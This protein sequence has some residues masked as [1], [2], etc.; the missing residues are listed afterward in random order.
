MQQSDQD[1][2]ARRTNRVTNG[3]GTA[4][5]VDL[6]GIP[7]QFS[8]NGNGLGSKGFVGFHQIQL[9]DTPAGQ[10]EAALTGG[11]RAGAHDGGV[12]ARV[13]VCLDGSQRCQAQFLR[14]LRAA[15]NHGS[16]AVVQ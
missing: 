5:D 3:N 16:C 8:V 6:A 13:G 4:V 14:F 7:A 15:Y 2:T 11:N 9:I 12:N 10:F 1:P